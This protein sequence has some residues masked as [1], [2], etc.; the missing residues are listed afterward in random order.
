M[1]YSYHAVKNIEYP[2]TGVGNRLVVRD[3]NDSRAALVQPPE[4]VDDLRRV[5]A[6]EVAGRFVGIDYLRGKDIIT[7][8]DRNSK[9]SPI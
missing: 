4:A 7:S 2:V 8:E 6:V 1:I 3:H 9:N 5:F